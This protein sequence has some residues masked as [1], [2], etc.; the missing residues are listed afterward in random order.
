MCD[1][2]QLHK[3][4]CQELNK[5]YEAKNHDYGDSFARVRQD[6]PNAILVRLYDKINRLSC[7]LQ[8]GQAMVVDEKVEDTLMD[9]ANYAIM[10]LIEM[11]AD[12]NS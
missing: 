3:D 12:A 6:V 7:L 2:V 1:K 5:V 9:L 10:E 8:R 11:Q 4:I